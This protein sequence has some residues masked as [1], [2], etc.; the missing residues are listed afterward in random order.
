MPQ[1][2]VTARAKHAER[3]KSLTNEEIA[4]FEP[5]QVMQMAVYHGVANRIAEW[6]DRHPN[7]VNRWAQEPAKDATPEGRSD[8]YGLN[9]P[10]AYF[11]GYFMTVLGCTPEGAWLML[12]WLEI[13]FAEEM[14]ALGHPEYLSALESKEEAAALAQ[15]L[16]DKLSGGRLGSR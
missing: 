9:G 12:R 8:P 2:Y 5:H 1:S 11:F 10:L 16:A 3:I 14:A 6:L 13:K 4:T 15:Q 7:T